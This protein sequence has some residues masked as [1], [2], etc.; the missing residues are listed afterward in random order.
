MQLVQSPG[1]PIPEGAEVS[2]ITAQDGAP[3]RV[4]F[5]PA[6][7]G[8]PLGTVCILQGRAEF[9]EKYAEAV[10]ELLAR[11]FAVV[12]F[13][14]RGQGGSY[15]AV[16]DAR[17]GHVRSFRHYRRDLDAVQERILERQCPRPFYGL[18][19][20]MGGAVALDLARTGALRFTRLV[21][22]AP[23]LGLGV[24]KHPRRAAVAARA[25]SLLGFGRSYIPGG[26]ATSIATKP[27]AG[28]LLT[29]DRRRYERNAAIASALGDG[30]IGDPT[31]GWLSAAF[32]HMSRLQDPY[33]A[34]DIRI[35]TLV[36]A[37]GADGLCDTHATERFCERLK[38]GGAIVIPGARHEILME[39][40][41]IRGQFW[42]AFDAFIPGTHLLDARAARA[43]E[44]KAA[45]ELGERQP[46]VVSS[47]GE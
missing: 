23:M 9:I 34:L 42:A 38:G 7:S 22:T 40:D 5:W 44:G 28:N 37:A 15:R 21:I 26:G 35:P 19:H 14:W 17:K 39:N 2:R 20:S 31:V 18:A 11:G 33:A 30:A 25:L 4:A 27:F 29:S 8:Q 10:E 47:P 13:D 6:R 24:V 36:V 43:A 32:S 41:A 3:L 45:E 1:N 16:R 46:P 12:A